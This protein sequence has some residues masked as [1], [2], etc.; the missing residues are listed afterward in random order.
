MQMLNI[1]LNSRSPQDTSNRSV[2]ETMFSEIQ[3]TLFFLQP[4][5]LKNDFSFIWFFFTSERVNQQEIKH[6]FSQKGHGGICLLFQKLKQK[7]HNQP[8]PK[9]VTSISHIYEFHCSKICG[10]SHCSW[11]TTLI[12]LVLVFLT[13]DLS[14]SKLSH[15][16]V[17][18][19]RHKSSSR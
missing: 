1:F 17:S 11:S 19:S 5:A 16:S 7:S 9:V 4:M 14:I 12:L 6:F 3:I 18:H 2:S 15:G 10:C 8:Y 13:E